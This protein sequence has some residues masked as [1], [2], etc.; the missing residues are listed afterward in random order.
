MRNRMFF[1]WIGPILIALILN[2]T[3]S[4]AA[5]LASGV[6]QDQSQEV[7]TEQGLV[8]M[9]LQIRAKHVGE[10][11]RAIIHLVLPGSPAAHSGLQP[12]DE[13]L[14]VDTQ[15]VGG[16]TLADLKQLLRGKPGSLVRL[17]V[18]TPKGVREVSVE[19]ITY[20]ELLNRVPSEQRQGERVELY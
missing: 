18:L 15:T 11:G 2:E 12:E 1:S 19:R 10:S 5:I 9:T 6:G 4:D 13:L 8:G 7:S 16:K 20:E 17:K 14:A 3:V